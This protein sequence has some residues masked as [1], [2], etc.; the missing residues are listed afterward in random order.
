MILFLLIFQIDSRNAWSY[1]F[2]RRW[3]G[4]LGISLRGY[5]FYTILRWDYITDWFAILVFFN[6]ISASLMSKQF[7]CSFY[8]AAELS[9]K[10]QMAVCHLKFKLLKIS[11]TIK[12][13]LDIV[14]YTNQKKYFCLYQRSGA[15]GR[16]HPL[17]KIKG[18]LTSPQEYTLPKPLYIPLKS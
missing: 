14:C 3:K 4:R 11:L 18:M 13:V 10:L 2:H 7:I 12:S 8:L 17:G 16:I 1:L 15:R 6:F 9:Y 5:D